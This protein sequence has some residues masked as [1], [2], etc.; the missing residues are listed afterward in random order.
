MKKVLLIL[1]TLSLFGCIKDSEKI[2]HKQNGDTSIHNKNQ[3]KRGKINDSIASDILDLGAE[4]SAK[5][6]FEKAKEL[7]LKALNIEPENIIIINAVAGI[8]ADLNNK[9]KS[10]YYF[11]KSLKIDST[12]NITYLNFGQSYNQLLEF[13]K[14]IEILN[15]GLKF[16]KV[17]N[18]ERKSYFYYNLANGYYKKKDYEKSKIFNNKALKLVK[19]KFVKED[20][21]ELRDVLESDEK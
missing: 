4:Q 6:N 8:Y 10:I 7:Y 2:I 3:Y 12:N 19:N 9:K 15:K 1:I 18:N 14:S 16:V 13:D 11:E 20:I 17:N 5:G 21:I